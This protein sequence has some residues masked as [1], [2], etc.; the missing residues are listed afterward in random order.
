ML[1]EP[2]K[3]GLG[4]VTKVLTVFLLF[5]V[6]TSLNADFDSG[7]GYYLQGDYTSAKQEFTILANQGNADAQLM[8]GDMYANGQGVDK[9]P[10]EAYKWYDIASGNGLKSAETSRDK[11]AQQMN[12]DE[13]TEAKKLADEWKPGLTDTPEKKITEVNEDNSSQ[14]KPSASEETQEQE[15]GGYFKGLA[16]SVTGLFGG[17]KPTTSSGS[18]AVI[19]VRG[20]DA[21]DLE[22]ASPD[23]KE[24]Q[25]MDSYAVKDSDATGFARNAKLVAQNI[26]YLEPASANTSGKSGT[27]KP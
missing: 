24:L 27:G 14:E 12:A 21:E 3:N 5:I 10:V 11:I 4:V 17:N 25:K 22:A 15:S 13:I 26:D 6:F 20:L 8:L 18:T 19:G 16:R 7:L 23:E 1:Y 9:D 2:T